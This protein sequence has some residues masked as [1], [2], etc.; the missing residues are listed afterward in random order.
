MCSKLIT[1]EQH[2]PNTNDKINT[3]LMTNDWTVIQKTLFCF[4]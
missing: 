4:E 1:L 2:P 3:K